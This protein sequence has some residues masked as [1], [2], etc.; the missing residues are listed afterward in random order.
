M[1]R[2]KASL[3]D[4]YKLTL[5]CDGKFV[6]KLLPGNKYTVASFSLG[7]DEWVVAAMCSCCHHHSFHVSIICCYAAVITFNGCLWPS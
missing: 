4:M 7:F 5:I 3:L 2:E 1:F 6:F